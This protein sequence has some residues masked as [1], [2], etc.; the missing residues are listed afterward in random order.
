MRPRANISLMLAVIVMSSLFSC[1]TTRRLPENTLRLKENKVMVMDG[2]G[3][4]A[5]DLAP[6]IKQKANDYYV[7]GWNPFLNVYNWSSGKNTRWDRFCEK[8]GVAPVAFDPSLVDAS[9]VGMEN[10]LRY[11]GYYDSRIVDSIVQKGRLATVIYRVTPG[12]RYPINDIKYEIKD[13]ELSQFVMADRDNFGVKVGDI[14]SEESLENESERL[15]SMLADNG[16]Y[17][18]NKNYFFFYADTVAVPDSAGL[19]VVIENYTRNER[20]SMAK[21]HTRYTFGSV[22][23]VPSGNL[24]VRPSVLKNLNRIQPGEPFSQKTINNTYE[25]FTGNHLFSTVNVQLS[26]ADS[27]TVDCRILLSP[28]KLQ[29]VKLNMEG[30]FN[31]AGLFGVTPS[32]AYNHKNVFG[33]GESLTLG[34]RGNFQFMLGS[35]VRSNEFAVSAGLSFPQFLLL[36]ERLFEKVPRTEINASYNYQNRPEYTR[37]IIS[38]SYGYNWNI[39]SHHYFQF[40]PMQMNI[41]RIFNMS[42]DF[43]ENLDNPYLQNAYQNHFDIGMGGT[44]YFTT[45]NDV[46]PNH[47]WFYLRLQSNISGNLLSAFNKYMPTDDIGNHLIWGVPYSQ[48]VRSELSLVETLKFGPSNKLSFA[49]RQ[50]AGIGVA[51]GNSISL[52]FEQLFYAG[53][54]NSLRG[55]QSRAVGPGCAPL[56]PSFSISNQTGDMHLEANVEFRFPVV[57]KLNGALFADVGNVWN[58]AKKSDGSE[59]SYHMGDHSEFYLPDLLKSTA[60]SFGTG[61]RL[62]LGLLL[63]RLD[64][65]VKGYDPSLQRWKQPDEWFKKGGYA[66]HFGIGYP[67]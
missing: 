61:I 35:P 47:S 45:A 41:V 60:F 20:P 51:Y 64:L 1:S 31:A 65:G 54:S 5:S 57:W 17:G 22:S 55:W 27:S 53:G 8:L 2:S 38:T 42:E 59:G 44:Y 50:L 7:F 13:E 14:L 9:N 24:K 12:K 37:N 58:H 52:P 33:G 48:F 15:A 16:Y 4:S 6:Y 34:F 32:V 10:H 67:F 30:S 49:F 23:L 66:L 39:A 19:R 29:S 28:S 62:D 40:Y 3:V 46:N 63:V 43:Y 56:D 18:F 11:L 36:P 26:E 25:R 21:P